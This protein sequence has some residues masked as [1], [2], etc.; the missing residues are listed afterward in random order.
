L[1]RHK[2]RRSVTPKHKRATQ[3]KSTPVISRPGSGKLKP[4]QETPSIRTD[5]FVLPTQ[6]K[7]PAWWAEDSQETPKFPSTGRLSL[8]SLRPG[9]GSLWGTY[10]EAEA[11]RSFERARQDF[12]KTSDRP[13]T[14]HAGVSATK[15]SSKFA[16]YHCYYLE[17]SCYCFECDGKKFCSSKC[18]SEFM[19]ASQ[20]E[21]SINGCCE[22]F[23]RREGKLTLSGRI[24]PIHASLENDKRA[25]PHAITPESSI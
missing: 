8:P 2:R 13:S 3:A 7:A 1:Q 21:C 10:D 22:R 18:V 19:E 6:S 17:F 9:T 12:I 24:C 25:V 15:S 5:L 16:C 11:R 14:A 23:W 4:L 20:L